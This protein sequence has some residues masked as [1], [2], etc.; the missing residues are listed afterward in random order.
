MYKQNKVFYRECGGRRS[1]LLK[2]EKKK[3]DNRTKFS[4]VAKTAIA[5]T[6]GISTSISF[7]ACDEDV[8]VNP[9]SD[10]QP[11]TTTPKSSDSNEESSSSKYLDIPQS[12]EAISSE[13]LEALSSAAHSAT[14]A[15]QA[16]SSSDAQKISSSEQSPRSSS[17]QLNSSAEQPSSSTTAIETS[18][19]TEVT[20]SAAQPRSSSEQPANSS[21]SQPTSSEPQSSSSSETSPAS[22]AAQ[23]TSS[24]YN[25]WG[26]DYPN[27]CVGLPAG[28]TIETDFQV[29][30]CPDSSNS[31]WPS[32]GFSMVTTFERDDIEV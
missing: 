16:K 22:S 17:T 8:S 4:Y 5:T 32:H 19:S 29:I 6:L 14:S 26:M 24:S 9:K 1:F 25:P 18:S 31:N 11:D 13:V 15:V 28:T 21:A 30:I 27:P 20:S 23:P 7:V 12:H 10:V 3:A 2:I